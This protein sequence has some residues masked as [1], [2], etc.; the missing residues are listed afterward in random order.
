MRKHGWATVEEQYQQQHK[1]GQGATAVCF[2]AGRAVVFACTPFDFSVK[3]QPSTFRR[4]P[5]LT[6][7]FA[8]AS[9]GNGGARGLRL[10][11]WPSNKVTPLGKLF[12]HSI[13]PLR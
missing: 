12:C 5:L 10:F 8:E 2:V 3:Q 6:S 11:E 1:Q 7:C 9:L 13:P 4:W